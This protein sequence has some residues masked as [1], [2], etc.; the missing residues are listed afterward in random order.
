M[1]LSTSAGW[2]Q[3]SS[4]IWF[5]WASISFAPDPPKR[6]SKKTIQ[7]FVKTGPT[8]TQNK[9]TSSD[10][11]CTA[12]I[13]GR[14][15]YGLDFLFFLIALATSA[16]LTAD[17]ESGITGDTFAFLIFATSTSVVGTVGVAPIIAFAVLFAVKQILFGFALFRPTTCRS[18]AAMVYTLLFGAYLSP[19]FGATF[20][21]LQLIG[22]ISVSEEF[23]ILAPI[24][25]F[26]AAVAVMAL[27][28]FVYLIY[29]FVKKETGNDGDFE[30][31]GVLD[32]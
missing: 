25:L 23:G 6:R 29:V 11:K 19:V 3:G 1:Y 28:Q 7:S 14:W 8:Q 16:S 17:I 26:V 32:S 31:G 27:I 30:L 4:P 9:I 22:S 2:R 15:I 13:F 18:F 5:D 24:V 20:S 21:A 10:M 12:G